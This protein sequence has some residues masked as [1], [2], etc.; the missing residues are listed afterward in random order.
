MKSALIGYTGFVGSNLLSQYH[1]DDLYNSKN[2]EDIKG[3]KYDLIVSAATS[4]LRWK[5]NQEPKDDWKGIKKLLDNLSKVNT[6]KFILISTVDV[7]PNKVGINEDTKIKFLDLKEAYGKHRYKMELFIKRNFSDVTIIRCPQ[8]YGDGLKKNFIYDLIFDNALDFTHKDTLMQFY[9][10]KNIWRDIQIAIKNKIKLINFATESVTAC[11]IAKYSLNVNFKNITEK[12]PLV[13][14][15]RTKYGKLYGSKDEYIYHRSQILK[16][17]KEF[18]V[19][20]RKKLG[21]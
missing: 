10:L 14:D 3:K 13:F 19:N 21:K 9:H 4:A 20:E 7:Y 16:E 12:P 6:K 11:Q 1:F 2:I 18:I 8:L 17:I 5:A 15:F